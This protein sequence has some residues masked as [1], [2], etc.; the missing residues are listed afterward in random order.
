[1]R[2]WPLSSWK[3]WIT[4]DSLLGKF[5]LLFEKK[6]SIL[7]KNCTKLQQ[8][9]KKLENQFLKVGYKLV[10]KLVAKPDPPV[11]PIVYLPRVVTNT[12]MPPTQGKS[13]SRQCPWYML[14]LTCGLVC[15]VTMV[16]SI[17]AWSCSYGPPDRYLV[18]L[19]AGSVHTSVYTY[20]YSTS[21][22]R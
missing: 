12:R 8:S 15:L 1:M 3:S 2:D 20:R 16:V 4:C 14:S 17:T 10:N 11:S 22:K 13:R 5:R 19:D 9:C 6:V 18:L 7:K 21:E